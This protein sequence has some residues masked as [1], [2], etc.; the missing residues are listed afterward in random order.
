MVL[1][2]LLALLK[3]AREPAGPKSLML[4]N[5]F[6]PGGPFPAGRCARCVEAKVG[7]PPDFERRLAEALERALG[8]GPFSREYAAHVA[9]GRLCSYRVSRILAR[10]RCV[11]F[12]A[13]PIG[14]RLARVYV[15]GELERLARR[16]GLLGVGVGVGEQIPK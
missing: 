13:E 1:K 16:C 15:R 11:V 10:A 8:D 3:P 14:T 9:A 6:A 5:P 12:C 4:V 7:R 2:K